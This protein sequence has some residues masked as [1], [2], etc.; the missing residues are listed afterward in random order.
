MCDKR[1]A[2]PGGAGR[3]QAGPGGARRGQ[4]EVHNQKQ[5][6]H[7]KMWGKI[8]RNPRFLAVSGDGET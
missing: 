5:E 3:G 8:N 2:G 6:P 1:R 7:T 4:A